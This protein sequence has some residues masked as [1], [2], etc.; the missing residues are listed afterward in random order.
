[1]SWFDPALLLLYSTPWSAFQVYRLL[2]GVWTTRRLPV[3]HRGKHWCSLC[4]ICVPSPY[5]A[6]CA[7]SFVFLCQLSLTVDALALADNIL[8]KETSRWK[9][10]VDSQTSI[11]LDNLPETNYLQLYGSPLTCA[12]HFFLLCDYFIYISHKHKKV[13]PKGLLLLK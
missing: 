4:E 11:W 12:F 10:Q 3:Q 1:M 7:A 6:P 5:F 13:S 9:S 8:F 2:W